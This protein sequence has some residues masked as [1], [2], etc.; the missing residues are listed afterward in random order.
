MAASALA[1]LHSDASPPIIHGDVKSPNILLDK[2]HMIKVSDFGASKLTPK[3]GNRFATFVQGTRGYLDPE[4]IQKGFLTDKSDVYS[5]GVILVELL[6][7]KKAFFCEGNEE[8]RNLANVFLSSLK[9]ERLVDVLD[10]HMWNAER[11]DLIHEVC[12]LAKRCLSIVGEER[13]TMKEVKE[14][15]ERLTRPQNQPCVMSNPEETES[16][17][18]ATL[19][20]HTIESTDYY[21][22]EKHA[23]R[24]IEEGR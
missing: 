18:G 10:H 11:R 14:E 23:V 6:T 15:L 19:N 3:D 24:S 4:Y 21:T 8:E 13:P 5:F 16:I 9:E 17:T 20:T 2:N 1:Y 12:D 7:R 22:S